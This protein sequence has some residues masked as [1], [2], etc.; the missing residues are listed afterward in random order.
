MEDCVELVIIALLKCKLVT[1]IVIYPK[2]IKRKEV[3]ALRL[4]SRGLNANKV[5]K[6][7][8]S[9]P[10]LNVFTTE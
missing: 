4:L 3:D 9:L 6:K 8:A 1:M 5:E 10:A 2:S 7:K